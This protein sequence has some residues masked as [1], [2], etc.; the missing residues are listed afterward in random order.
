[1]GICSNDF[2]HHI[3]HKYLFVLLV[4][5][6]RKK[7]SEPKKTITMCLVYVCGIGGVAHHV[8]SKDDTRL[9]LSCFS[10]KANLNLK[11][12]IFQKV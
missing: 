10:A 1:M 11:R 3:C 12:L 8:C 7:K 5:T 9:S 4:E 6:L 2:S